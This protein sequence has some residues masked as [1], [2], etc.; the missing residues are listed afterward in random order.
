MTLLIDL[1]TQG[2]VTYLLKIMFL[3]E[4][5]TKGMFFTNFSQEDGVLTLLVGFSSLI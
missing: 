1:M 2:H 4:H 5:S 3:S